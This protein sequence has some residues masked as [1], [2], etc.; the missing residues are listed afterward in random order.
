MEQLAK[1]VIEEASSKRDFAMDTRKLTMTDDANL[2]FTVGGV[3]KVVTPTKLCLDQIGGRVG[4]PSK[5]LERMRTE[6][7]ELLAR[8][9]N[10][11]FTNAPEVRMLRTLNNGAN[12][13]RAFLSKVYRPLDNY[14]LLNAVLPHLQASGCE[15]KACELTDTRL[16]IQAVT[17]K[18]EAVIQQRKS[19]GTQHRIGEVND[20]VQAGITISNSEVGAGSIRVEPL[21][22]RLV[23]RN[24][25]VLPTALR[26][27]HVGRAGDG[28]WGEG[29][30]SEVFSDETRRLDDRAFW[31]KV[32]DVVTASLNEI[33]FAENVAKLNAATGIDIGDPQEAVE[34]VTKRFA[35]AEGESK[36][37]LKHLASGG[38]LSLW[39]LT[40]CLTRTAEDCES[41]DRNIELQRFGGEVLELPASTFGKN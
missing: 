41:F 4:I 38:D 5:Y 27:H 34:I 25:L 29:D 15:I 3:E 9:V 10:H 39:G 32:N 12:K 30:A 2:R 31:A 7:P 22:Y 36:N 26:K 21:I 17:P 11:W 23:C 18:L 35:L 1:R 6:A 16:Y 33:K 13:A 8:N 40:N 37:C 20:V 28:E 24:G 14:D 19:E